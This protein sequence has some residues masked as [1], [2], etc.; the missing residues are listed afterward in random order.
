M[1]IFLEKKLRAR[2]DVELSRG[3]YMGGFVFHIKY[4]GLKIL[5]GCHSFGMVNY[6]C[7]LGVKVDAL[8]D[9]NTTVKPTSTTQKNNFTGV[10]KT[11]HGWI[12]VCK[13]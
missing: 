12:S 11:M 7:A 9:P 1:K 6:F 13:L 10:D 8:G 4:W 2:R 3:K 5:Q